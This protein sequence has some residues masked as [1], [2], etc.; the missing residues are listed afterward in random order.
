MPHQPVYPDKVVERCGLYGNKWDLTPGAP[1]LINKEQ[2]MTKH[3]GPLMDRHDMPQQHLYAVPNLPEEWQRKEIKAESTMSHGIPDRVP[4][5]A[6]FL[7][8]TE[9]AWSPMHNR[10]TNYHISM[11]ASRRR[12]VLWESFFNEDNWPYRSWSSASGV[13]TLQRKGVKRKNA[14]LLLL[15]SKWQRSLAEEGLDH[16][17][18]INHDGLISIAEALEIGKR[19]W[20]EKV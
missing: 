15:H 5:G 12:W 4:R 19:V 17:H 14:S 18:W 20:P 10:I 8:Q 9:W 16:F 1:L 11:D 3:P 13:L 2:F 6:Y 7:L